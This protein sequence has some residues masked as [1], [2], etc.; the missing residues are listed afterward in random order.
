MSEEKHPSPKKS[1]IKSS[2]VITKPMPAE[3]VPSALGPAEMIDLARNQAKVLCD[4]IEKQ[5]LYSLIS[6]KK[7]VRV[8]GWVPL[9]RMNGVIP[10]EISNDFGSDGRY[11]ARVQLVRM[12]TGTVITEA[13]GECGGK[14]EPFWQKR[15]PYAR[16]SMAATRATGKACRLAYSWIVALAGFEPTPAEEI[17]DLESEKQRKHTNEALPPLP[18]DN[19]QEFLNFP[20]IPSGAPIRVSQYKGD[21]YIF[22]YIGKHFTKEDCSALGLIPSKKEGTWFCTYDRDILESLINNYEQKELR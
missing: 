6:G 12:D 9:A 10:R 8:E 14:E 16:R 1:V 7:Y 4:L 22:V 11:V 18:K 15:A 21:D 2:S 3:L 20:N 5:K 13:S 17:T 19:H